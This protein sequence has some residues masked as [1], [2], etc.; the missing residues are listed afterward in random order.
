MPSSI[1]HNNDLRFLIIGCGISGICMAHETA[2]AGID[3]MMIDPCIEQT[4]SFIAGG[5]INPISG[6]KNAQQWNIE[7][8]LVKA[9]D[10]Y[11]EL[12]T[13][14]HKQIYRSTE[15][16]KFHKT[17]NA[18][19]EWR[20]LPQNN[21]ATATDIRPLEEK[22]HC[23]HGGIKISGA[24]QIYTL[25][26]IQSYRSHLEAE[27]KLYKQRFIPE[28][29]VQ[30]DNNFR[31][32]D[33]E[34]SHLILCQ[35]IECMH[36]PFFGYLPFKPDKGESFTLRIDEL[37]QQFVYHK[38]IILIPLG[39]NIF[40]AGATDTWDDV[41]TL[42]T[43]EA[44]AELCQKLDELL[45][46]P[47]SILEHRAAVRPAMKDR[48]PVVGAHSLYP[49]IYVLNGMGAKGMSLAPYYAEILLQHILTGSA[50][51]KA[52]NVLRFAGLR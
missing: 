37:P 46:L 7:A 1:S 26:L 13:L 11:G 41:S 22:I 12:S 51:P 42:P 8:L 10:T 23:A 33:Q 50:I 36:D 21:F 40:W 39:E 49:N 31:Y 29:L 25:A 16:I 2:K 28:Q 38:G 27:N 20:D 32:N 24:L 5:L 44:R 6:R 47:Y 4:S 45:K 52:V 18:A 30:K 34:Y 14:L 19:T 9:H 3:L 35:G 15:I 17:E 43:A 48:T